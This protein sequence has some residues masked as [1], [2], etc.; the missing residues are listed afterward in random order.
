MPEIT[1][2]QDYS[3]VAREGANATP[4]LLWD[5]LERQK[6]A[7]HKFAVKLTGLIVSITALVLFGIAMSHIL[8]NSKPSQK[9]VAVPAPEIVEPAPA[10]AATNE[11][12]SLA[13]LLPMATPEPEAFEAPEGLP[14]D[15]RIVR[16][17]ELSPV[18]GFIIDGDDSKIV[19]AGHVVT[20]GE[21][22][23]RT[24]G[25]KFSGF[26]A[27]GQQAYFVDKVGIQYTKLVTN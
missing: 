15:P 9:A 27:S 23:S 16:F 1:D 11:S 14:G 20:V 12:L 3:P 10:P 8:Q 13:E 24:F 7:D 6:A 4:K 17:L 21:T 25:L 18:N 19:I 2:A 5:T 22:V 26:D